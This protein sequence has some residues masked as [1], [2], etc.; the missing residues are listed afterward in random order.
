M[1]LSIDVLG[2]TKSQS[3]LIRDAAEYYLGIL[4]RG[5]KDQLLVTIR[6]RKNL[7]KSHG[8]KADCLLVEED[9]FREFDVRIDANMRLQAILRCLAHEMVHVAQYTTGALRE[10]RNMNESVWRGKRWN[11]QHHSYYD[12]PWEIDAL[13][14]EEGLLEKF[15]VSR[16][17]QKKKW[18][19]DLDYA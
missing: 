13:G 5:R 9:D 12:L 8:V 6:L 15:V 14:K 2:A 18:Y 17:L 3:K 10:G 11:T 16:S 4:L 7:L 19:V 1:K